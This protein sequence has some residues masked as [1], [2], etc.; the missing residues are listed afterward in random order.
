MD[1]SVYAFDKEWGA[2][3]GRMS[4][5]FAV[6]EMPCRKINILR[7]LAKVEAQKSVSAETSCG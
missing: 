3:G 2:R 4:A 7:Q 5:G 6:F 1:S